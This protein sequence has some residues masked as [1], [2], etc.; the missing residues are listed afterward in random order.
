MLLILLLIYMRK[1]EMLL[2]FLLI[3]IL[4]KMEMLKI[5]KN[6]CGRGKCYNILIAVITLVVINMGFLPILYIP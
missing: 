5:A 3:Y 2:I 4:Q 1:R 6:L